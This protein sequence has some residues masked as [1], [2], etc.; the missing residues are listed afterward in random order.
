MNIFLI[1][2]MLMSAPNGQTMLLIQHHVPYP[3]M[4]A[5]TEAMLEV[6]TSESVQVAACVQA[7][8]EDKRI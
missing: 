5:C 7:S 6:N 4:A 3:T 8:H 1:I 2:G